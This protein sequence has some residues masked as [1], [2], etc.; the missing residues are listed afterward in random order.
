MMIGLFKPTNATNMQFNTDETLWA[1]PGC[2]EHYGT[3][4]LASNGD[5]YDTFGQ[6]AASFISQGVA[7]FK[8]RQAGWEVKDTSDGWKEATPNA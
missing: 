3:L 2:K 5:V 4:R 1:T 6:R 7:E 8:L